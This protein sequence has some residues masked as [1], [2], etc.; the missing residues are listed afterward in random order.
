MQ[1][2]D[3]NEAKLGNVDSR[4]NVLKRKRV[5][6]SFGIDLW[7]HSVKQLVSVAPVENC[8]A[9]GSKAKH[10]RSDARVCNCYTQLVELHLRKIQC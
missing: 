4:E 7:L 9:D 10:K 3:A 1:A 6:M 8:E 2:K 5:G